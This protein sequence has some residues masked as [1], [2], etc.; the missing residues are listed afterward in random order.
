MN[1]NKKMWQNSSVHTI[2][3]RRTHPLKNLNKKYCSLMSVHWMWPLTTVKPNCPNTNFSEC[4]PKDF[5][6]ERGAH[7]YNTLLLIVLWPGVYS[8]GVHG[9]GDVG[10][11]AESA[12]FPLV[13]V[14]MLREYRGDES[15]TC[16]I[17]AGWI[18]LRREPRIEPLRNIMIW[19]L[20][21]WQG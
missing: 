12:G 7:R 14:W 2:L 18:L 20:M 10:N 17:P 16:G 21:Q 5:F 6:S 4:F 8:R 13:W 15:G 1:K 9:D 19:L 3:D 11:P